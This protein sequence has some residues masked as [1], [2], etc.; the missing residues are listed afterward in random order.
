M[1]VV[2]A[3]SKVL[4][5]RTNVKSAAFQE[6][7]KEAPGE[8]ATEV[9]WMVVDD[10]MAEKDEMSTKISDLSS[11]LKRTMGLKW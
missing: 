7:L 4:L 6:A 3:H 2:K 1:D 11:E 8:F 10:K 5:D 9:L